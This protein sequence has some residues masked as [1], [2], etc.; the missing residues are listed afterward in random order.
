MLAPI[1][2]I[3]AAERLSARIPSSEAYAPER[4]TS[5]LAVGRSWLKVGDIGGALRVLRQVDN[6]RREAL[7]RAAIVEWAGKHP[8]SEPARVCVGDTIER[9][10]VLEE[11]LSRRDLADL[12]PTAF[13]LLSE[14]AVRRIASELQDPFSAGNVLVTLAR[15]QSDP[16]ARR[17]TLKEAE[18]IATGVR[19][20]DRDFA[21][22][23]VYNGYRKAGLEEDAER[24]LDEMVLKPEGMDAPL[25]KAEEVMAQVD[26][27]P[28]PSGLTSQPDTPLA[29][30]RRF[31][32]YRCNDLKVQFLVDMAG[33]GGLDHPELENVIAGDDFARIEPPRPPSLD[34]DPSPLDDGSFARFFFDRPVCR[35]DSDRDLLEAH[36]PGQ[37]EYPEKGA[38]LQRA[39]VL[40]E[41]F[42]DIGARFSPEQIEQGLWNLLGAR[43][44]FSDML[45]SEVVPF[46]ARQK[47]VRAMFYPFSGYYA[48]AGETYE[49][50]VF[51]MWWD[52]LRGEGPDLEE[53]KLDVLEQILKLESDPCRFSALHGLNHLF[54]NARASEIVSRYLAE[55]R[56]RMNAENIAWV[57][58][59]RDG[60]AL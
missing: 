3:E 6:P 48:Q 7:L 1:D 2:L 37:Q 50:S 43:F 33:V 16:V 12:V 10:G 57:E 55:N 22:R 42:G 15:L 56:S 53:I 11:H 54:P 30:L 29:R 39:T 58:A 41:N 59:C 9:I 21:L 20:G 18:Q 5:W 26:A 25:R 4:N 24:I 35:H 14:Q 60:K 40:F 28:H 52:L 8:E 36:D 19:P 23:W 51:F 27:L 44:D 46:E 32:E 38:F 17:Q 47:A 13:H 49:G 34:M 31:M 45:H